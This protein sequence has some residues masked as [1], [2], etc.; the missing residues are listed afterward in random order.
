MATR[1][2]TRVLEQVRKAVLVR[3]G[4]GLTDG[5][6]L[7]RFLEQGDEAAF[8]ALV[9]RHG[10]M[11]LGACRRVLGNEQDAE[12]AFQ[13]TFLV[14][15]RKAGTV[16]PR[17]KVANWLYGARIVGPPGTKVWV[18]GPAGQFDKESEMEVPGRIDLEQGKS[19]R[20]KLADI[21]NR[22]GAVRY[23]TV[24]IARR[25]RRQGPS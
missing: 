6:L 22:R 5:Q 14:L 4:A 19:A 17:D 24:E 23:P 2:S 11:V 25:T 12:D 7:G 16:M 13:A 20:L 8:E 10:P 15:A 21:P 18:M 9:G 3:D 1:S